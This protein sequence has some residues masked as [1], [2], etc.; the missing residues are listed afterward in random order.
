MTPERPQYPNDLNGRAA[1]CRDVIHSA[2]K[3]V[4]A[5]FENSGRQPFSMKG[6]QDFLTE[7]DAAS[8][9]LIR[10]AM[11]QHFPEDGFL[12]EEGGGGVSDRL[13]VVDPVDGT[14][15]F[16][17][18]IPHFCISIAY[19]ENGRTEIG[20]IYDPAHDELYFARRGAGATRNGQPIEVSST[21]DFERA[22]VEMGWSGRVANEIYLE[23]IQALLAL[24]ANVRRAGS[25]ALALAYVADG[26]SDGY[27]EL[28]MNSWDCLAG[29]LL[30]AEA[31]GDVCPYMAI[32]SLANG[33]P[34]LAS[35]PGISGAISR[36]SKIPAVSRQDVPSGRRFA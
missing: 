19:I 34:V 2:G 7:T 36:A 11:M 28:H 17:R 18:G 14:A 12:G 33:G 27:L 23:T 8:E 16:A 31:G 25:G 24:G 4:L 3:L 13:W 30:V 15:N 35:A 6:P 20:A 5:G 32:G 10:Q 22:S 9:A 21:T 1:L 29:L 26:R